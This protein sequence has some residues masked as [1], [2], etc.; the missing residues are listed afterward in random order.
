MNDATHTQEANLGQLRLAL[1]QDGPEGAFESLDKYYAANFVRH[2]DKRDYTLEQLRVGLTELYLG[3]PD[4][5]RVQ[6]DLMSDG[7]RVAY[8]WEAAGTHLGEYM[9]VRPTG[10]PVS[11]SGITMVRFEGGLITEDWVSW[12]KASLLHDLGI[13]PLDR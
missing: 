7:E 1:S 3:F 8:R 9:G 4:L 10:R 6:Y 2:G 11:T 13:I 5:K 12:N